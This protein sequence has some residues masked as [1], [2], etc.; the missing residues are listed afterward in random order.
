MKEA[1]QVD[2]ILTIDGVEYLTIA[3]FARRRNK[4]VGH[5]RRLVTQGNCIRKLSAV[6]VL[7]VPVIPVSELTEFPWTVTGLKSQNKPYHYNED[8][9]I[10]EDLK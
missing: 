5:V 9:S 4:T 2:E 8:D 1:I 10:R 6:W 7:G 3:A